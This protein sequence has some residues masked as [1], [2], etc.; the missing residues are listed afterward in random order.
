MKALTSKQVLQENHTSDPNAVTSLTFTHRALSD[1]SCLAEFKKLEKLDL[2]FNNL[3]SLEGLKPCV[4]LKWLSVK[5]NKLRSLKG[6]EG[7]V[8]LTVLN[9]GSN[10][11]QSMEEVSSLV[12]LRALILNDNEIVSICRL[13][14][15]KEL[16]T[17]VLS[18]NPISKIGESLGKANSITKLSLSNC[19]IQEI[20]S[21]IKYCMELREL[22]LAHNEMRALPSE[23]GRNTKIQNLDLGNNL[24]TRWSDLKILSSL[25][26]LKNLNLVGN[27]VADKDVL[28]K[29]IKN[30][31][32]SLHIF[33]G[34]PI[35]KV[36]RNATAGTDDNHSVD[37]KKGQKMKKH[38]QP[39]KPINKDKD[40]NTPSMDPKSKRKSRD[41]KDKSV[42]D[43]EDVAKV[44]HDDADEMVYIDATEKK[45]NREDDD[46]AVGKKKK[47]VKSKASGSLAVQ[48]LSPE[49]EVGL[50]GP[51]AWDL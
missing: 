26:N 38:K 4:N 16:N 43:T 24:I 15:M 39:Y 45:E 25:T 20:D 49:P 9:A 37:A 1:V 50:G 40:E 33:N 7:C 11:L 35:D 34:R 44:R 21:S 17:I 12:R 31:V 5:Q 46:V 2:T 48:L 13:D 14:Q 29:K 51:S 47:K 18:R 41:S 10:M 42:I 8:C 22:R 27:P 3:S 32:P 28:T 23:L 30:L 19:K 6:I 36:I